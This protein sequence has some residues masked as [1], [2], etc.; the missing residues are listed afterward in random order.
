MM[1]NNKK[2][3]S[4]P[5]LVKEDRGIVRHRRWYN[6]FYTEHSKRFSYQKDTLDW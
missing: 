6:Q 1:W 4:K 5:Q 3:E 2:Y